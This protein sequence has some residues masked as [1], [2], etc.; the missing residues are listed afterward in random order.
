MSGAVTVLAVDDQEVFRR[1]ARR[2]LDAT[3]DFELVGEAASGPE[4]LRLAAELLPD[5]VLLDIRMP[6]MDGIET[7]RRL[8]RMEL[9]STVVLISIGEVPEL[10]TEPLQAIGVVAHLR[11]QD[12]SAQTLRRTWESHHAS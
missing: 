11:K 12:L 9:Q 5:L 4:A 7:A 2:L 8:M 6:G 1:T 10:L 3:P